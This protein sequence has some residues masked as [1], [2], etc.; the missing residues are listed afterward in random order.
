M[1]GDQ[2]FNTGICNLSHDYTRVACELLKRLFQRNKRVSSKRKEICHHCDLSNIAHLHY[3]FVLQATNA[4]RPGNEA[5]PTV[6]N[7]TLIYA[8]IHEYSRKLSCLSQK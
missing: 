7:T 3:Y 6:R 1:Y 8:H 2:E 5:T 4:R